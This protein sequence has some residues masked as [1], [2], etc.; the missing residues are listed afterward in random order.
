MPLT[1]RH[2]TKLHDTL[3]PIVG[4]DTIEALLAEFPA[5]ELDRPATEAFVR[6]EIADLR[7]ELKAD[8]S[9]VEHG[10]RQEILRLDASVSERLRQQTMWMSGI[11]FAGIAA[12]TAIA[13]AIAR[14]VG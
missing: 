12:S 4:E 2:R 8:I 6:A 10:L 1:Q 11:L 14:L 3:S 7:T 9:G 13:T 5:T